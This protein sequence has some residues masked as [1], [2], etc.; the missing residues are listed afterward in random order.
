M[1]SIFRKPLNGGGILSALPCGSLNIEGT[2]IPTDDFK[3][4]SSDTFKA[5]KTG[6][7]LWSPSK[8]FSTAGRRG[9]WIE[10]PPSG[11]YPANLLLNLHQGFD[12]EPRFYPGKV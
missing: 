4:M 7:G 10:G 2:R 3:D 12:W 8:G 5:V 1:I 6:E 11:R 9:G